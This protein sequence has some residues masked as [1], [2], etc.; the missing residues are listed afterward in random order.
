MT[1]MR[2]FNRGYTLL[3]ICI[4]L[5]IMAVAAGMTM[6]MIRNTVREESLW[7]VVREIRAAALNCRHQAIQSGRP[8]VLQ[9]EATRPRG[10]NKTD[11]G[12]RVEVWDSTRRQWGLANL[13]WVFKPSGICDPLTLR[14]RSEDGWIEQH[15]SPL[16]GTVEEES[17][18]FR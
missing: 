11:N 10:G 13:E 12:L 8:Q 18:S 9:I 14:V 2:P 16:T 1:E 6:P 5:A 7:S 17:W 4:V 3:E 15:F